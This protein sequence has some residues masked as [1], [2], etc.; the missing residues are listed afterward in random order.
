MEKWKFLL[1]ILGMCIIVNAQVSVLKSE[2]ILIDDLKKQYINTTVTDYAQLAN[3]SRLISYELDKR[4]RRINKNAGIG[5]GVFLGFSGPSFVMLGIAAN[6]KRQSNYYHSLYKWHAT[7][8][9]YT[10][11]ETKH[12]IEPP[13]QYQYKDVKW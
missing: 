8:L 6:N 11:E 7:Q 10:T 4:G 5:F 3:L 12:L 1:F 13:F 2:S 9:F